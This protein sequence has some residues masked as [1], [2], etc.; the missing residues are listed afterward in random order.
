M[1]MFLKNHFVLLISFIKYSTDRQ[2]LEKLIAGNENFAA[3][4]RKAAKGYGY[5]A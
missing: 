5:G 1:Y 3:M 2:Q 4:D